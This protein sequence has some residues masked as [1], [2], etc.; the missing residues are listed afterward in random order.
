MSPPRIRRPSRPMPSVSERDRDDTPAI[1]A[2]PSAMQARKMPKPLQA[3]AQFAQG[4]AQ[5]QRR[6]GCAPRARLR[7]RKGAVHDD[8]PKPETEA[9]STSSRPER[10]PDHPVA[11]A[12][13]I[14][15]VRHEHQGGAAIPL[16]GEEQVDDRLAGGLVEIAGRLVRHQD[17]RVGHDGAGD[18]HALLLAAGKLRR[19]NA[20][21]GRRAPPP[22]IPPRRG[23]THRGCRR[24]PGARR[25]FRA[26]SWWA[27]DG[28]IGTRCR[29]AGRE[30]GRA[31]PRRGPQGPCRRRR[32][33]RYP[34][35]RGRPW[36]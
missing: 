16:Q 24:V 23:R 9:G 32:S 31:H 3:A 21:A 20:A 26:P 8:R 30:N 5:D 11:E 36:S 4:E 14:E 18:R 12:S 2:T 7:N 6:G 15:V 1:A 27:R 25:R 28:R 10:R 19:D 29:C 22:A 17:R 35:A 13:Q 33:G 34:G